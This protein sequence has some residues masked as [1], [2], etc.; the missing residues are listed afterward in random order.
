[1]QKG[2]LYRS[3]L[4][5][6]SGL[7]LVGAFAP[8]NFTWLAP[9]SLAILLWC[10]YKTE[11]PLRAF[12]WGFLFG[13]GFFGGGVSWVFISIYRFGG[14]ALLLA[15]LIT[16]LFIL[17]LSLFPALVG[18]LLTR[19]FPKESNIKWLLLFPS[20]WTLSEWLRSVIFTG[21]PWNLLGYS[22]VNSSLKGFAP[23]IGTL[24]LT[25]LVCVIAALLLFI[26]V[27]LWKTGL[28]SLFAIILIVTCGYF[29]SKINWT[30]P[31]KTTITTSLIQGDIPQSMK[32][33][34]K[35]VALSL[36]RYRNM[37][38]KNW[39]SR[40][41]VWPEAA[42]PLPLD[43]ATDYLKPLAQK[44]IKHHSTIIFGVPITANDEQYYN[45]AIAIGKDQG[46]Y[47]KQHLVPFGEYIPLEQW[48][49]K[50]M[51]LMKLPL[52]TF[53]T[54]PNT[55]KWLMVN[56][57]AIAPFIC[58]EIAYENLV[59]SALPK[60]NMLLVITNDAWFGR[61]FAS[62][63]HLQIAQMRSLETGR[64]TLFTSNSGITAIITAKG[65]LK[66]FIPPYEPGV[67]K[68][69]VTPMIGS[70]PW[71]R[72]GNWPLIILMLLCFILGF[73]K[74]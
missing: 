73:W 44:A 50:L 67:L 25:F 43:E 10:W 31:L 69:S 16:L 48:L 11:K 2:T 1:M 20:C 62:I 60:A 3:S 5:L 71:I 8:F 35:D 64:E 24:G 55:S 49:G 45:A 30:T 37:T 54:N 39:Q 23:V 18:W 59:R 15:L 61:S 51:M 40:L 58:Y 14:T 72:V 53:V 70:T 22:Q 29:L 27:R 21:F 57:F 17:F 33:N 19:F 46:Q 36:N 34:P 38:E 41:I 63:Q 47:E 52:S 42:I 28:I 68:N 65:C 9:L 12:L 4:S 7:L 26:T 6:I 13:I 74:A 32:W 56:H 66:A